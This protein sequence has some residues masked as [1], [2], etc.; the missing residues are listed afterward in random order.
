MEVSVISKKTLINEEIRAAEV[1]V[2]GTDGTQMGVMSIDA[3]LECAADNGLD[4]VEIAPDSVP[5]VC[6]IMDYGKYRFDRDKREKEQRRNRVVVEVKEIQLKLNI[7]THDLQ[8]KQAHAV[9]FINQGNKVKVVVRFYNRE[10]TRPERGNELL[11]R[12]VE[13]LGDIC[14]VEKEPLLEGRNM[15]LILAPKKNKPTKGN[16]Q[17]GQDQNS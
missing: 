15:I 7:D 4:L 6:K 9:K 5:P 1:R 14:A 13:G 12:F 16:N 17:N 11:Q 8:T 3:A 2:I 10:I